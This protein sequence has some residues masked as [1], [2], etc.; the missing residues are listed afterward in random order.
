MALVED[1]KRALKVLDF[2]DRA[3]LKQ[4]DEQYRK[5]IHKWHPDK[6]RENQEECNE[7]T[8]QLIEAH[9]L[10]VNYCKN[11]CI[12]FNVEEIE[13][14]TPFD[15]FWKKHFGNDPLWGEPYE[16]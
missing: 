15:E 11:Y 6:C 13:N 8:R 9:K 4:I 10:L 2:P 3:S 16:K 14:N 1:I 7:K 12:P 5:L